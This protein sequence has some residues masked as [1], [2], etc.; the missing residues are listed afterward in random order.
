MKVE[1]KNFPNNPGKDAKNLALSH[2]MNYLLHRNWISIGFKAEQEYADDDENSYKRYGS[3]VSISRELPFDMTGSAGYAYQ[4][5]TYSKPG[6][7]FN[8]NREDH[9]HSAGAGLKKIL[10]KSS[11]NPARTASLNLN[12]QHIWA[13]SNIELYEYEQDLVQ[14]F[15]LYAF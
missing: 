1:E 12:Y 13:F 10:W 2:G 6:S 9:Q 14:L 7:L 4:F 5:S 15:L 8:K 3:N 11:D